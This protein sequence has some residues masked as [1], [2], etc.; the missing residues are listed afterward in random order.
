MAK[1]IHILKLPI[2]LAVVLAIETLSSPAAAPAVTVKKIAVIADAK[3]GGP[4]Q[5][6]VQK[7]EAALR[8]K[9]VSVAEGEDQIYDK[10]PLAARGG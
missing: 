10:S 6:G 4:A 1:A 2:Y 9:G 3:L 7:L 8:A 5:Y